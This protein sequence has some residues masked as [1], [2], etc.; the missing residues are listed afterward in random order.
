[1]TWRARLQDISLVLTLVVA[2]LT[3]LNE[4]WT[5]S[6]RFMGSGLAASASFILY[7]RRRTP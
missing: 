3:I 4:S 2:V 1:M 5:L 6:N 7:R